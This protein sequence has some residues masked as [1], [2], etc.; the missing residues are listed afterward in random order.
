ML[1]LKKLIYIM[2]ENFNHILRAQLWTIFINYDNL[3]KLL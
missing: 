2:V 1:I 3:N